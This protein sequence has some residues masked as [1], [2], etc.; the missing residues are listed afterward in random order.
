MGRIP[1]RGNAVARLGSIS[2]RSPAASETNPTVMRL[3]PTLTPYRCR[4]GRPQP[5]SVEFRFPWR[6]ILRDRPESLPESSGRRLSA[7]ANIDSSVE[8]ATL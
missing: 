8:L 2:C 3:V 6:D 4:V 1:H 5:A 7:R